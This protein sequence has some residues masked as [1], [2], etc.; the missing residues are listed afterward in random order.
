MRSGVLFGYGGL[1][2]GLVSRL[3]AEFPPPQPLVIA[4]GGMARIVQ[5]YA[6]SIKKIEPYLTLEG[7]KLLY[8]RCH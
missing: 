5:P 4:T 8:D 6:P 3:S 1:V 7:L 2:E